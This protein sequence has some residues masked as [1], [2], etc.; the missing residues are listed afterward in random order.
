VEGKPLARVSLPFDDRVKEF[1]K[2]SYRNFRL[3]GGPDSLDL[4]SNSA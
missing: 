2:E 4:S 1:C 3:S